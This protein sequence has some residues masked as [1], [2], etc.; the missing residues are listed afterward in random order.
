MLEGLFGLVY[1][2]VYFIYKNPFPEML[3]YYKNSADNKGVLIFMLVLYSLLC[4]GQ[5]TF[6]VVTNKIYS[7]MAAT[8]SQYFLNPLYI[9]INFLLGYDFISN[10]KRNYIYFILNVLL[11]III[12]FSGCVYNEFLII[13]FWRLHTETHNE[14]AERACSQETIFEMKEYDE[15][16]EEDWEKY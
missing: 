3:N 9:I 10:G 6:R 11:S 14:I 13:F 12:S 1:S 16:D 2:T 15:E 7:P 4:G 5:N 8:L